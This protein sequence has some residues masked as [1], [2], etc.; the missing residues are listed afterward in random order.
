M[1][2]NQTERTRIDQ[3]IMMPCMNTAMILWHI[4]LLS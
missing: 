2:R 4:Q 1:G 3:Q